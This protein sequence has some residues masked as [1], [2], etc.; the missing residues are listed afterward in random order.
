MPRRWPIGQGSNDSLRTPK[1]SGFLR[2]GDWT[3]EADVEQEKSAK[4]VCT[5][6]ASAV[7]SAYP[8]LQGDD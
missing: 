2:L 3:G 6:R 1:N 8:T 4:R 7:V 5:L